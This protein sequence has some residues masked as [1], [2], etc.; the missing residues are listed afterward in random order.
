VTVPVLLP[1]KPEEMTRRAQSYLLVAGLRHG[2][3]GA[4]MLLVPS[5]FLNLQGP[6]AG[7]PEPWA[8]SFLAISTLCV[9]A[10]VR[11]SEHLA[12]AALFFST[13]STG[14]LSVRLLLAWLN[15]DIP[16]ALGKASPLLWIFGLTLTLK[17]LIQCRQPLR[18]P[19]EAHEVRRARTRRDA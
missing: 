5:R 3:V 12:Q 17:D 10:A 7:H 16:G 18:S 6:L 1:R 11:R 2:L 4:W 13:C 9:I 14:A 8:W 19:F 15:N